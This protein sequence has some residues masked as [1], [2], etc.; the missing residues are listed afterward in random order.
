VLL[1]PPALVPRLVVPEVV[2]RGG[3]CPRSHDT[4]LRDIKDLIE[5]GAL[6]QEEGGGRSTSYG[7]VFDD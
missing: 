4:A 6:K 1:L 2:A 7:L 3:R 5:R